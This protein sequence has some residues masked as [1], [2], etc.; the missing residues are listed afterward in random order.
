MDIIKLSENMMLGKKPDTVELV[1][2]CWIAGGAIRSWFNREPASDIDIFFASFEQRDLFLEKNRLNKDNLAFS[3]TTAD[4]YKK[5]NQLIQA[6]KIYKPT[7]EELFDSFDFTI[8]QFAYDDVEIFTT[9]EAIVSSL[10]KHLAVHKIQKGY[11]VDSL[12]RAF[13]YYEK[14]YKPCLGT[15]RDLALAFSMVQ[16]ATIQQQIEISPGGGHRGVRWD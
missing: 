6:I 5:G 9:A 14:G 15:I 4:T 2:D 8:C 12:R 11:E 16:E 3:S 7:V 1:D 13:K 10:R